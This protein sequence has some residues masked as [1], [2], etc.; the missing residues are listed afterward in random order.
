MTKKK[1]RIP[2]HK[3]KSLLDGLSKITKSI[4]NENFK[5]IVFSFKYLDRNQGQSFQDWQNEHLLA[6]ALETISYYCKL[7]FAEAVGEKFKIY[8]NFPPT[9]KT[10]FYHPPH[11]PEDAEWV[12]MHI[13]GV[14]K[15]MFH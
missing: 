10:D 1:S 2:R 15:L 11:I 3:K 4:N 6:K 13:Q 8:G 9:D 5:H 7:T 12:S 14:I